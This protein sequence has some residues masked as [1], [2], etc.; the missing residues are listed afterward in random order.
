[1]EQLKERV[2]PPKQNETFVQRERGRRPPGEALSGS[3][4]GVAFQD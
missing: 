3:R 1:M 2:S 4:V